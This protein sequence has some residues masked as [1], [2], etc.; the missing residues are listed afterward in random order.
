MDS[1]ELKESLVFDGYFLRGIV[2]VIALSFSIVVFALATKITTSIS[3]SYHTNA[4][5]VFVGFLFVIGILLIAYKG[6]EHKVTGKDEAS[7]WNTIRKIWAKHEEDWV[8]TLGGIAAMAA[9]VCPTACDDCTPDLRSKIHTIAATILFSTV[10]YFC[11]FAFLRRVIDKLNRDADGNIIF[12]LRLKEAFRG[13]RDNI[14]LLRRLKDAFADGINGDGMKILRGCIYLVCGTGI[15]IIMLG[16]LI[17]EFTVL[18]QTRIAFH[19]TYWAET[20]ALL[21][22]GFAWIT[23]SQPGF[24]KDENE[25]EEVK[26]VKPAYPAA[27]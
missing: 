22:F 18:Q 19:I 11:L 12:F 10:V 20:A 7:L 24:L 16:L 23:A 1:S 9:A 8:A 17:A 15:A 21:L 2:G 4:R 26:H 5:D 25:K 14:S 13:D 3:A 27:A 6:H